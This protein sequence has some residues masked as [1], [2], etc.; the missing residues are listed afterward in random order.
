M[1]KEGQRPKSFPT[2]S[3]IRTSEIRTILKAAPLSGGKV[4]IGHDVL[5]HSRADHFELPQRMCVYL[6]A[7]RTKICFHVSSLRIM[8]TRTKNTVP[9]LLSKDNIMPKLKKMIE[10]HAQNMISRC[11]RCMLRLV[12]WWTVLSKGI[13]C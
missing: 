3:E 12:S 13:G 5:T 4:A 6:S 8:P 1:R 10:Q 7:P 9:C 2:T 11:T